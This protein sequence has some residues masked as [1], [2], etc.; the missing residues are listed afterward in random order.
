TTYLY[1]LLD[2]QTGLLD[3]VGNRT[4]F[5]L[6][7]L[8]RVTQETDPLGH[9]ITM[10]YDA[11]DRLT[12]RTDR[13]GRRINN[14]YDL[15]GRLT[16]QTWRDAGGSVVNTLTFVYDSVGN[17]TVAQDSHGA[18]TMIFDAL[19]RASTIK[20]LYG[21]TLTFTYDAVGNR[22]KTQDSF[23][24][25]LTSVY[26]NANRLTSQQFGGT[27]QTPLRFDL[28]Y[29]ERN[30]VATIT[31]FS[32]LAGTGKVGES[33]Y[34]YDSVGRVQNL[35]HKNGSNTVLENYTYT[36]DLASRV[37]SEL[38]NGGAPTSYSYDNTN[39]LT[40]DGTKTY[41]YDANGNRTMAGY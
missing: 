10:A 24:G 41:S 18:S 38:L 5:V 37:T 40:N 33:D 11:A 22:T 14:S 34:T 35:Q 23:G 31:R 3:P 36:Y 6:D 1:D 27:G 32:D 30:Q 2:N 39:Q 26:D 25:V 4:T 29:T 17:Q 8:N 7:A 21:V 9:S 28:T 19:N 15:D 12:S 16:T 20:R 13:L